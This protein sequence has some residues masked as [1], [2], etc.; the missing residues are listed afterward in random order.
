MTSITNAFFFPIF[1]DQIFAF[2]LP[3]YSRPSSPPPCPIIV[4][5]IFV[6]LHLCKSLTLIKYLISVY[7]IDFLTR[8]NIFVFIGYW[9]H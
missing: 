8:N 4:Q 9:D 5:L 6:E 1:V 7:T 2:Y 3:C